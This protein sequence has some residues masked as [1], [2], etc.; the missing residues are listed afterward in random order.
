MTPRSPECRSAERRTLHSASNT[1]GT[2]KVSEYSP[3]TVTL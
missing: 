1:Y 2:V 3:L